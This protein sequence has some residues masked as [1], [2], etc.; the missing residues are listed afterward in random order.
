[1]LPLVVSMADWDDMYGFVSLPKSKNAETGQVCQILWLPPPVIRTCNIKAKSL[2]NLIY[3][4]Q[5]R[6]IQKKT[7]Q[8]KS[9]CCKTKNLIQI[10][11]HSSPQPPNLT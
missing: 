11:D 9:Y 8:G 5:K 7:T 6:K 4:K 3:M 1:M 2:Q 10:T